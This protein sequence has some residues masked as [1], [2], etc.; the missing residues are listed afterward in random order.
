MARLL[1]EV[2]DSGS[3][4]YLTEDRD[5]GKKYKI[6]G[7]FLQ[8][9]SKNR[10]GRIYPKPM[11]ESQTSRF[12]EKIDK[13]RAF[14]ELD[15]PP[16]PTVCLKNASHMITELKWDGAICYG[17]AEI[18]DE[19]PMGAIAKAIIKAGAQLGVS[20]RGVGSLNNGMVGEDFKLITVDIVSD[21]S[22]QSAYVEG[23]YEGAEYIIK[24]DV[25]IEAAIQDFKNTVDEKGS[26]AILGAFD[27][28]IAKIKKR[29]L[30]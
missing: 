26:K 15:H 23:I 10:N 29:H 1:S 7:P 5:S 8:A 6:A 21:P 27:V 17:V 11:L 14:G 24:D 30:K 18:L 9:D 19:T 3:L 16:T 28:M 20:S 12:Q 2:I 22:A 25:V 13:K 4:T